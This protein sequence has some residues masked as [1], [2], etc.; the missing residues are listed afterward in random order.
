MQS[1]C[2]LF[3]YNNISYVDSLIDRASDKLLN[4][5]IGKLCVIWN[6][7]RDTTQKKEST[8]KGLCQLFV[9]SA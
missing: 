2:H 5:A 8:N 6:D 1:F 4:K 9:D 3:A 7:N